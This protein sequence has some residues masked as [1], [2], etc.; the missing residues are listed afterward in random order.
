MA[1]GGV[2]STT[3]AEAGLGQGRQRLRPAV[4]IGLDQPVVQPVER[5][6]CLVGKPREDVEGKDARAGAVLA[7]DEGARSA[8]PFPTLDDLPGQVRPKNGWASGAVRKSPA[9]PGRRSACR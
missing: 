1:S 7:D 8:E 4:R 6:R 3:P 5:L 9:R 2:D